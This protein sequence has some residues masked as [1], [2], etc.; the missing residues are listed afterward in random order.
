MRLL[1]N[2]EEREIA[3]GLSLADLIAQLK[4]KADR[5]AVER[6][7][8]IVARNQ[9]SSTVLADRDRLEIVQFVGGGQTRRITPVH[10]AAGD[11]AVS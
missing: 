3:D 11:S 9:W 4:M 6:N 2:G 8:E 5:V 10:C 7:G 1:I